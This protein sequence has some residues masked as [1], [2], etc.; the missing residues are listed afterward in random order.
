MDTPMLGVPR[1]EGP[2]KTHGRV[3]FTADIYLPGMLYC[4][5]YTSPHAHAEIDL[6]FESGA[7]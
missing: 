5:L 2:D 6:H 4:A 3:T 7:G 1:Q